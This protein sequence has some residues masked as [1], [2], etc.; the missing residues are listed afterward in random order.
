ME[1]ETRFAALQSWIEDGNPRNLEKPTNALPLV[2]EEAECGITPP[3]RL[4]YR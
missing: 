4:H 2:L 1:Q 3:P